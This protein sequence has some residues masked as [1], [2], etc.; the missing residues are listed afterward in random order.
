M[1]ISSYQIVMNNCFISRALLRH[2]SAMA[3]ASAGTMRANRMEN[4]PL[5]DMVKINKEKCGPSDVVTD[6]LMFPRISLQY[7]GKKIVLNAIY[8]FTGKQPIQQV[9][10][11]CDREKR[12][13]NIEQPN[14]LAYVIK[15]AQ[16]NGQIQPIPF[17][18]CRI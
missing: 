3:F 5:H 16:R 7:V 4:A 8:T 17:K 15:Y 14:F 1:Q 13:V 18:S 6:V 11:Y 12:R 2:S 10:R 9:K